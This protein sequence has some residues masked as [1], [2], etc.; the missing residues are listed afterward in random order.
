MGNK[1]EGWGWREAVRGLWSLMLV[2]QDVTDEF[3]FLPQ[4]GSNHPRFPA[5]SLLLRGQKITHPALKGLRALLRSQPSAHKVLSACLAHSQHWPPCRT[6]GLIP[7]PWVLT[8]ESSLP[9]LHGDTSWGWVD[10]P[11]AL[12]QAPSLHPA[13]PSTSA[14]G[15]GPSEGPSRVKGKTQGALWKHWP[16]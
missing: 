7:D 5:W 4:D 2:P 6:G 14:Q 15:Q 16:P 1:A 8:L 12:A 3:A 11:M 13:P 9:Q 10:S